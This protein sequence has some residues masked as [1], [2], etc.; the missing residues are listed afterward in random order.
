MK[1]VILGL[2]HFKLRSKS[3]QHFMYLP[4]CFVSPKLPKLQLKESSLPAENYLSRDTWSNGLSSLQF[5]PIGI[6]AFAFL[7]IRKHVPPPML[8]ML[9]I[10]SRL[11]WT[12]S[13]DATTNL[14]LHKG[15]LLSMQIRLQDGVHNSKPHK[16]LFCSP[17]S[18]STSTNCFVWHII[19]LAHSSLFLVQK[20]SILGETA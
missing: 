11:L 16:A 18:K 14:H 17:H 12:Q 19:T 3:M 8:S 1:S 10:F 15:S 4:S 13:H 5:L 2:C 9:F 6:H 7:K 20:S